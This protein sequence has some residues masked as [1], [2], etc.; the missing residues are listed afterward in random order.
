MTS[1]F[2]SI[3]WFNFHIQDISIFLWS[4]DQSFLY[5]TQPL[6]SFRAPNQPILKLCIT[7]NQDLITQGSLYITCYPIKR[8]SNSIILHHWYL[9]SA[10][11]CYVLSTITS[12]VLLLHYQDQPP[13]KTNFNVTFMFLNAV[14]PYTTYFFKDYKVAFYRTTDQ[15]T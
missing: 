11:N 6:C 14:L 1:L 12:K 4:F 9:E 10:R 13:K 15:P 7:E 2:D 8:L 3:F 5:T